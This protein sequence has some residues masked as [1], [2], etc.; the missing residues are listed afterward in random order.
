MSPSPLDYDPLDPVVSHDP[1]PYYAV[2]RREAPVYRVPAH[3]FYAVS[4]YE[5]VLTVL[6]EHERFSSAAMRA[7]VTRPAQYMESQPE[8][9]EDAPVAV[10]I[11]G[12]DGA[13]HTRLRQ[14]VSRGFTPGRI[15]ALEPRIRELAERLVAGFIDAGECDYLDAYANALPV[16]VIAELLGVDP[17]R[18]R[19]FRRWADAMLIAVFESPDEQQKRDIEARSAEMTLYLDDLIEERR[20]RP[21]R[22]LL[23]VLLEVEAEGGALTLDEARVFIFTLLVAGSTTTAHL[24][25]SAMVTLVRHPAELAKVQADLSL[26]PSLVE[27]IL[28]YESPV[29]FLLRT[30]VDDV[31]LAGVKIPRDAVVAPIFG[32]ANR[33]ERVF[34]DS[35]RFD[36]TRNPKDHLAFGHGVHFCLGA[37]LARLE[38][39][40]ALETLLPRLREPKLTEPVRWLSRLSMRGPEKLRLRFTPAI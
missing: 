32:S 21:R 8:A 9:A 16:L 26:V 19:A 4:R 36:V 15:A 27:E 14:V 34:P 6:R 13:E 10:S 33:D 2:L 3:G 35:D 38:S 12:T 17:E 24:L 25:G 30:A 22:D 23:S 7:A 39:R 37:A 28:R 29:Q 18:R 20:R 40:I 5:H 31:E 11:V 1:Y